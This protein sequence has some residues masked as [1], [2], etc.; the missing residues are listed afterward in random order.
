MID[1]APTRH[2]SVRY[3]YICNACGSDHVTRDAW[4]AWDVDAQRWVLEAAFDYAYCHRCMMT[5]RLEQVVLTSP[6]TFTISEP[7]R[8]VA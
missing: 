5:C 8:S 3:A 4:A 7:G 1:P 2:T 6:S